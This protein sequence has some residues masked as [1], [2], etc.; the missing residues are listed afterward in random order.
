MTKEDERK[1]LYVVAIALL[2]LWL[3]G[4]LTSTI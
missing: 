2:I 3:V 4:I 1:V